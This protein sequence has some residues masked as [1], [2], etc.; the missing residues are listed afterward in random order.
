[1]YRYFPEAY[2]SAVTDKTS[3]TITTF[4]SK[5]SKLTDAFTGAGFL[6]HD[7]PVDG[8]FHCSVYVYEVDKLVDL[9]K[10]TPDLQ[11]PGTDQLRVAVRSATDGKV[12]SQGDLVRH[13]LENTLLKPVEWYSTLKLAV[14]SLPPK[15]RRVAL[16]GISYHIPPSLSANLHVSLLGLCGLAKSQ[17][18]MVQELHID[19]LSGH[20]TPPH[21]PPGPPG[22]CGVLGLENGCAGNSSTRR[23][24]SLSEFPP[25]SVAIVGIAGRFPG[26]N[27]VDELWELISAG[28]SMVDTAPERI[29]LDCLTDDVSQD[30]WW[31]NFLDEYDVFDH[32]FFGKTAREATACDPQQRKLLEVVYEALEFSGHLGVGARSDPTDYGCYIGAVM[33]N[34]TTNVGCHPPTAYATTG[35][36]RAFLSGAVS[37]HFGWTGPAMTID[38]ACSSSLVAIHTACRAIAAGECSRA[39]AGGT[40]IITCPYDYR[41]LKAAGFLS[42]T[43][44][45]KPFDAGA[46]GYCRGEAVCVVVLKS[47]SAAIEEND[48][49]L[50]V[51]VG[52]ATN[53][54][55]KGGSIVVPDA[56]A[57]ADILGKVLDM[58]N[59]LPC[60]VTYV[61]AHGTGTIVGDPIEVSSLRKVFGGQSKTSMLH[62]SSIKGNIGHAEAASGAAG[63]IKTILMMRHGQIPPQASYR[64]LNPDIPALEPDGMA[65]PQE[66]M[67]WNPPERIACVSNYGAA[68]N[69]SVV[70][71][72]E[73]PVLELNMKTATLDANLPS[74][75]PLILSASSS[76]SLS[77]NARK[78]LDWLRHAR[79]ARPTDAHIPDVLFNLAHRANPALDKFISTP[80]SDFFDLESVVCAVADGTFPMTTKPSP[81][82]VVLVFGGQESRFI[83]LSEAVYKSSQVFRHHLDS[84][85]RLLQRLGFGDLYP[86]IFQDEPL[87]DLVTLHL[88]LFAVQYSSARAWMDCGLKVTAVIGHSLGQFTA[89][90]IS[91]VLSLSDALKLVAGR[92]ALVEKHWGP[93]HG[94]MIALQADY[95]QVAEI[96]DRSN[97]YNSYAEIACFNGPRS[98]VVVGSL[99]TIRGI[100]AYVVNDERLRGLVRSQRLDITHG[101]HSRFTEV[102]LPHL[103]NLADGLEWKSPT[104][105]LEVCSETESNQ[106]PDSRLVVEHT[107]HAVYFQQAVERL[108]KKY[109]QATW[110]EAGRGFSYTQL[111]RACVE[112]PDRHSF[113][114]P[115]LTT[116]NAQNSL[117]DVIVELWKEGHS[118][119]HWPFHRS[120]RWQYQHLILPPYQFLKVRHWLPC[121]RSAVHRKDFTIE[122]EDEL[123]YDKII[124]LIKYDNSTEARFRIWPESKR[125]QDLV[126]G[127]TMC[128]NALMPASAYIELASRA[129]LMLQGDLQAN[130]WAPSVEDLAMWAPIGLGQGLELPNIA[131]IMRRL[132]NSWPSWS[133]SIK[134]EQ[135]STDS[136]GFFK[137]HE[138]TTGSVHLHK[139]T[140]LQLSQEF[141]RF[142]A[143]IGC[144]RWEQIMNDPRTEGMHGNHIYR[145]FGLVVKYSRAFRGIKSIACLGNETAG[146]VSITPAIKDPPDQRLTDTPMIDSFLQFGGFLVNYFNE[147]ESPDS[148]F[149]CHH[150]QRV[151]V[152]PTFSPDGNE[153]FVLSN[154][155]STDENNI[156]V[157]V[158]VSETRCRKTVFAALGM[159]YTRKSRASLKRLLSGPVSDPELSPVI[160]GNDVKQVAKNEAITEAAKKASCGVLSKRADILQI[161][162]SVAD[163]AENELSGDTCL[164]DIGLDSLGATEMISDIS[165]TL[166]VAIDLATFLVFPDIDAVVAHVDSRLGMQAGSKD[167][168]IAT[169]LAEAAKVPRKPQ[170]LAIRSVS[171]SSEDARE[172]I[173][174]NLPTNNDVSKAHSLPLLITTSIIKSFEDIRLSFDQLGLA[175]NALDYWSDVY[176][177]DLRLVL[178]YTTEAFKRLG[179]DL[180][181]MRPGEI[182]SE[183]TGT[184]PRHRKL[185]RR[186][187]NLLEEEGI[188]EPSE[189]NSFARTNKAIDSMPGEEI[190][191]QIVSKNPLNAMIRHL[192]R[193]VGPHLSACLVGNQ[194][195]L[196]IL[197]GSRSNKKWLEELYTDWPMLVTAI[198]LLG[199]FLCRAFMG[200]SGPEPLRIL[201]VGAGTGGTTRHIVNLLARHG[202]SFKYHFTDISA[203]LVKKARASFADIDGMSFGVLDVEN[204]P[205]I[206]FTEA[207][208]VIISSNCIHA[209]KD[210]TY[211]LA[212]LRKMLREDGVL[213][214]IE[215][216]PSR[217]LYVFDLI[218]GLLEGWWLFKDVRT[219]ALADIERWE[220]AFINAGFLE[221]LW[222]D[223]VSLEARTVRV[224]CGFRKP[225]TL[226]RQPEMEKKCNYSQND[227]SIQKVIYKVVGSQE[228]HADI[229]CPMSAS[230]AKKMPIALMIHGGSHI[231]FSR[232]DIRPPQTRIMLD[233]G[234]LPISLDH[235]LCP[236]TRLIEGPMVDVCD[237]LQWA[238]LNLPNI[239]LA[240]PNV[241]PD[242]D[243]IVL[244]GWSSGGQLAMSTGWTAPE[245]GLEPPNAIL[246]FYCPT[247]YEDDWWR[248]PIQPI[249]AEDWGEDY[250]VLE[251]VQDEAITN[252]GIIGAWEPLS[253]PRIRNDPRARIVL[254]M[255]WKAQTLPVVINGLFSRGLAALKR[256][257]VKDWNALPL[258]PIEEIRRCSPLAQVKSGNYA[259][260][261][262]LVHGTADDLIPWQQSL[263]TIKEMK[264]RNIDAHLVLVQDGPHVCDSS[265]DSESAGWQ[266]VLQAYRW[267]GEHAFSRN[268]RK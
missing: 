174:G 84:C 82:P 67:P 239:E 201:E 42:P 143:L 85:S 261:T 11:F 110:I 25:H 268:V 264:S 146:V 17:S 114:A 116:S 231:I 39:I 242:S 262:F 240:N 219:H 189:H 177:D 4:R 228:V 51:I 163:V 133:F 210:I 119:Q 238:R 171:R 93:E 97:R 137:A 192:L 72:R 103:A 22:E 181:T 168:T 8:R 148:L 251:A 58:S 204:E 127:H 74:R 62:F 121:I 20:Q 190:F 19:G 113:L 33:N 3:I 65:I 54:N 213:A 129:A 36:G 222:S 77:S 32:K 140:D 247:D 160:K 92:A 44:Q 225:V 206:E 252:Y 27:S 211:S 263:R 90:C 86:A 145:A 15:E 1:M 2:V 220:Q 40:N 122:H 156:S 60:D 120:Q 73:A 47:L 87:S 83:G 250:D 265:R 141:R 95:Q 153:W 164:A 180:Q 267:L 138:T 182:L 215:M 233:L 178:A 224:I 96:L 46:D 209:T 166:N 161:A 35:T 235:R 157:D 100:E 124:S 170:D 136:K 91:E 230:T 135:C 183:M 28:K 64:L 155:T 6:V 266:A 21:T 207:F 61:E 5:L 248:H 175:T 16:A 37:H 195:V 150:I 79:S 66:L 55:N 144:N 237:A 229:Y 176:P 29:G 134:V 109:P 243:N 185:V 203:S 226:Q 10:K 187:Y 246:A 256:P 173:N 214:L 253:D 18:Q 208:H 52:S 217:P 169:D 188:I 89:F 191:H 106:M 123:K 107:R 38:T 99:E 71:I 112:H 43:G 184:L 12:I 139:R 202:I 14:D 69:N 142:D 24:S 75:W 126:M 236:E 76:T 179:C 159:S 245:R 152:G 244:V 149:V 172:G 26:A 49:I 227:V 57:Q 115:R 200:N 68:G 59:I 7:V 101:F 108:T 34:Y 70:M 105:H 118:V 151:Q 78:L 255:N 50:G 102:L 259:T 117:V 13:I 9:F 130:E 167:C 216:T 23:K 45:C 132:D 232:K 125:F 48:H 212:N 56:K 111:V 98:H 234:L 249:G 196:Q 63:L 218:V 260:P 154:M 147:T 197:F 104:V 162:A 186:L 30:R 88:A 80:V 194:D 81:K 221:V 241:R 254:H 193:A 41:D 223:G 53:Q 258:P 94:S 31:G 165:S 128:D 158:Y 205:A 198:Q 257:E 199:D 131:M